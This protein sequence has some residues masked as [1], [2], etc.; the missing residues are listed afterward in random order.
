MIFAWGT[1]AQPCVARDQDGKQETCTKDEAQWDVH[2]S[3]RSTA[4]L[5]HLFRACAGNRARLRTLLAQP[6]QGDEAAWSPPFEG[7]GRAKADSAW[8]GIPLR[9][10]DACMSI[11]RHLAGSRVS[12]MAI[13]RLDYDYDYPSRGPTLPVGRAL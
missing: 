12:N 13:P 9:T 5:R 8:S 3:D 1:N 6:C 11:S 4:T 7:P 10:H 2:G